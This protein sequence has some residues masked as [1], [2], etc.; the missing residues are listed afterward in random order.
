MPTLELKP[1]PKAMTACRGSFN[2][3]RSKPNS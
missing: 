3:H 2:R 1:T